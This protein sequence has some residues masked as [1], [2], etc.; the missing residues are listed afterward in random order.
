M[1]HLVENLEFVSYGCKGV[2]YVEHFNI[3]TN[4]VY[5]LKLF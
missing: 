1:K 3:N 4:K 2:V 5:F